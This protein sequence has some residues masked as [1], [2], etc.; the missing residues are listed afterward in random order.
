MIL[1]Y[2][3]LL[4]AKLFVVFIV[5]LQLMVSSVYILLVCFFVLFLSIL[6]KNDK[7]IEIRAL[8]IKP[9]KYHQVKNED[10]MKMVLKRRR[11]INRKD[12]LLR[13]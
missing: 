10:P 5:L 1:G 7:P 13:R 9:L 11:S 4:Q 6:C 12:E 8:E 2:V 3:I